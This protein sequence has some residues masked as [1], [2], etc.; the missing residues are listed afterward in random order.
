MDEINFE[1]NLPQSSFAYVGA[2]TAMFNAHGEGL[3]VFEV[4]HV[5]GEWRQIQVVKEAAD[6]SF[7]A[8]GPNRVVYAVHEGLDQISAF[9]ID[10][11]TG[12]LTWLNT[13][14]TGGSTPASLALDPSGRF[15]LVGNYMSG[16]VA[17]LP[18]L[19]DGRVGPVGQLVTLEGQPGP[20]PVEQTQSHPHGIVFDPS[21]Q[22][23]IVPDKGF[24]RVFVFA[25]DAQSGQLTPANQ[26]FVEVASGSGPRHLVFHPE[27]T[28]AYLINELA[29]T[30]S[31]YVYNSAGAVLTH[32]QTISTLDDVFNGSNTA[33]EIAIDRSGRYVYGSNRGH[34]SIVVYAVDVDSGRLSPIQWQPSGGQGPRFFM[35]DTTEGLLY[36]ANQYSDNITVF[37]ADRT[38]GRLGPTGQ[39]I[40]TGS[41]VCLVVWG[42]SS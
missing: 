12:R 13:E 37:K 33:A 4:D 30:V 16:T 8:L 42:E 25:F 20:D 28:Y 35:L 32:L 5:S 36:A 6:P 10:P 31:V 23:V 18:I 24:D 19:E 21:G 7:L 29:S 22:H 3:S 41:P 9:A 17:V 2:Y 14:S 39:I 15:V 40:Q 34:D 1:G 11:A 26:P 38:D 27:G